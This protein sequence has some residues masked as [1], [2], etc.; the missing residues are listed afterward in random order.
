GVLFAIVETTSPTAGRHLVTVNPTTG[1]CTNIGTLTRQFA[2]LAFR[3]N[4]VLYGVTGKNGADPKS[5]FTLNTTTAQESLLFALPNGGGGETIAFHPNGLL[6]H[7]SGGTPPPAVFE[8][9]NVDTQVVTPISSTSDPECFSMGYF[10]GQLFGSDYNSDLY[11]VDIATGV[12]TPV[13]AMADQLP[14]TPQNARNRGLAFVSI[15]YV[16]DDWAA[17]PNGT[18]PDGAGP[19]TAMGF[20]AFATITEGVNAVATGGIVEVHSGTYPENVD[21]TTKAVNLSAGASPGQVTI[22]G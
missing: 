9:V 17:V 12:R 8:S 3:L 22:N 7:S 5:L 11:S 19:A 21:T 2:C 4:G 14:Q 6:Y 10:H 18:D 15:V 13:G 16:D 1:V 20:D